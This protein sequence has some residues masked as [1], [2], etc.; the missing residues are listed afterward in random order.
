MLQRKMSHP[1]I[2]KLHGYFIDKGKLYILL[3]L[4]EKGN[5]YYYIKEKKKLSEIEVPFL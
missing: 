4:A 2:T 1:N 5:L 3:E